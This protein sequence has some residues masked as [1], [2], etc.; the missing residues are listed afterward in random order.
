MKSPAPAPKIAGGLALA[1]LLTHVIAP[2]AAQGQTRAQT[3]TERLQQVQGQLA[4]GPAQQPSGADVVP[5][6][7][8]SDSPGAAGQRPALGEAEVRALV[9]EGL[10]VEVLRAE[11]IEHDGRPVYAVTV[12]NP[13]GD[14]NGAL[15][16]STLLVDG[17]SGALLGP[18]PPTPQTSAPDLAPA[19]G[20]PGP[21]GSGLEIRRRTYR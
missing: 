10:G 2:V 3:L 4:P 15:M 18:P 13:P 11:L 5:P 12:M 21:E 6:G 20:A 7:Q 19:S 8:Q 9:R 14:Y 16:V 17:A 1:L